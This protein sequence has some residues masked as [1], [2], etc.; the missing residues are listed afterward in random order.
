MSGRVSVS[1]RILSA[2]L[3]LA[4][5]A[6]GAQT[7]SAFT[8]VAVISGVKQGSIAG[9]NTAK[10]FEGTIN[11]FQ[12]GADIHEPIDPV[13]GLPTGRV[14]AKPFRIVKAPDKATVKLLLAMFGSESLTVEI[15]L[16]RPDRLTGVEVLYHRIKLEGAL[17]ADFDMAGDPNGTWGIAEAAYQ[18]ITFEDLINKSIAV[19]DT[20]IK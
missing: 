12:I 20:T 19:F 5:V 2:S 16:Y 3:A 15:R 1:F 8:G 13:S 4:A 11:L 7:A 9:D 17:I 14:Q 6:L 18:K 10:G